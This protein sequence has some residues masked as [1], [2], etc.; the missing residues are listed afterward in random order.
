MKCLRSFQCE[1]WNYIDLTVQNWKDGI[2]L[3]FSRLLW[4]K[5]FLVLIKKYLY[6]M[7]SFSLPLIS[8][9]H[10]CFFLHVN[11]CSS[12]WTYQ[13]ISP[14]EHALLYFFCNVPPVFMQV[15]FLLCF[16]MRYV[17]HVF[18]NAL[19]SSLK[20]SRCRKAF[21]SDLFF[22]LQFAVFSC[23]T[24]TEHVQS[25]QPSESPKTLQL[26]TFSHLKKSQT[27]FFLLLF[28]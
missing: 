27:F 22:L 2:I 17:L 16:S 26:Y 19:C 25:T 10:T 13:H 21:G 14:H 8:E 12:S 24:K 23:N 5:R 20:T 9:V 1:G 15:M 4:Q 6:F 18:L 28:C 7:M 11:G 3:N